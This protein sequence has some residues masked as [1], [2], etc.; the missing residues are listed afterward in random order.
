M[1]IQI[2]TEQKTI[3][4]EQGANLSKLLDFLEKIFP[5][6]EW[7]GYTLETNTT[8]QHWVNPIVFEGHRPYPWYGNPIYCTSQGSAIT[9]ANGDSVGSLVFSESTTTDTVLIK[10]PVQNFEVN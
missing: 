10:S 9:I 5:D 4:L 7:K 1:K 2:D 8:I 6:G 3:K